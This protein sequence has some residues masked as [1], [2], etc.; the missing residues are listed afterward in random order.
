MH[1]S[2]GRRDPKVLQLKVQKVK[3]LVGTW[4]GVGLCLA[5]SWERLRAYE[6][7][8]AESEPER[9]DMSI[10]V[11]RQPIEP[12]SLGDTEIKAL[13]D[14]DEQEFMDVT[15]KAKACRRFEGKLIAFYDQTALVQGCKMRLI[16]DPLLLDIVRRQNQGKIQDVPAS[17]YRLIPQGAPIRES[18]LKGVER[19]LGFAEL[20]G[21]CRALNGEYVTA[22][23]TD[24]FL[25]EACKK[26]RFRSYAALVEHNL[27]KKTVLAVTPSQLAS[28]SEGKE[29]PNEG[30]DIA[31]VWFKID[32]DAGWQRASR[33]STDR[34]KTS[35]TPEGLRQVAKQQS[36]PV[37]TSV[38][39]SE[40]KGRVVSFYHELYF[41]EGCTLRLIDDKD[42]LKLQVRLEGRDQ[43]RD[44]TANE[45]KALKT[46]K[47]VTV[48]TVMERLGR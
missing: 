37:Q 34:P 28:V 32:G 13:G 4:V 26:R 7:A 12:K 11:S 43:V 8:L 20:A 46:G 16:E 38:L 14:V 39:C 15:S 9:F 10:G 21:G 36:A 44:L 24:Y 29:M 35:D 25:V 48:D 47:S 23:G 19:A 30:S 45:K 40:I 18:D 6:T 17:V 22:N 33:I 41:V 3:R 5:I 31:D 1:T 27:G 2:D 42:Q